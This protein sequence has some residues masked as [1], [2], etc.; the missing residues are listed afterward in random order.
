MV[1]SA[2]A[3]LLQE[4]RVPAESTNEVETT[5][6]NAGWRTAISGCLL[7][8]GGG[9]SAG[10]AVACRSHVGLSESCEEQ[11]LPKEALGRFTVKQMG[12]VCKGGIHLA[13]AYL[14]VSIGVKHKKNLDLLQAMAAVLKTLAGP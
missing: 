11:F 3:V 8:E 10:V 6:R 14:H 2:D 4:T 13:S 5:A 1:S 12:A 7:G 9:K